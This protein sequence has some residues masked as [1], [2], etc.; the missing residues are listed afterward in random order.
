[1]AKII[2]KAS[3]SPPFLV[4]AG[5]IIVAGVGFIII[6]VAVNAARS[7]NWIHVDGGSTTTVAPGATV[8]VQVNVTTSGSGTNN[9]WRSTSYRIQSGSFTCVDTSDHT[10]SGT[11]TESFN[12]TAP[13]SEGTYD[14]DV[15]VYS[16]NSCQNGQTGGSL[17]NSII[18]KKPTATIIAKKIICDNE[19]DLPNWGNGGLDITSSTAQNWVNTHNKCRIAQWDF[20]WGPS[21]ASNPGDNTGESNSWTT[22]GS[23]TTVDVSGQSK[24]WV[25]EVWDNQFIPFT[26]NVYGNN[27]HN[28]SAEVYCHT[29]VLNYD[30]YDSIDNPQ[31]G[32][33]YYCVGFNVLNTGSLKVNKLVDQRWY[34]SEYNIGNDEANTMGFRWN[35]DSGSANEM[36]STVSGLSAG[37]HQV[38]EQ[39]IADYHFTG[40]FTN[41]GDHSCTNPEGTTLPVS[42]NVNGSQ[43]TEI[44][45]CNSRD[46]GNVNMQKIVI[47]HHDWNEGPEWNFDLVGPVSMQ[48]SLGDGHLGGTRVPTGQYTLTETPYS[49]VGDDIYD[50]TYRCW[51][52]VVGPVNYFA[53]GNGTSVSFTLEKNQNIKCEFTNTK[54]ATIIVHKNVKSFDGSQDI[55]DNH[56]FQVTA[57]GETKNFSEETA[58]TFSVAPGAYN[59]VESPDQNYTFYRC[60]TQFEPSG[61]ITN[62]LNVTVS[63]GQTAEMTC[64][65]YKLANPV[66]V[67]T[68]SVDK[69][70]ANEGDTLTYTIKVSNTGDADANNLM[71]TDTLPT[72]TTFVSADNGGVYD[73]ATK[74]LTW[75]INVPA[76]KDVTL[77]YQV[78]VNSGLPYG[79][80]KID[81]TAVVKCRPIFRAAAET[82]FA[83]CNISE[84]SSNKVTTTVVKVAETAT[85]VLTLTKLDTPDPV[86]A[87]A[88]LTYT[89]NFAVTNV[90]ATGVVMTDVIPTNT[91]FVSASTPGTYDTLTNKVTWNFGNLAKGNYTATLVVN[92]YSPLANGTKIN[93]TATINADGINPVIASADTTVSSGPI[94]KMDKLVDKAIANAGDTV[95]Y[96]IKVTNDGTDT[97][98]NV[99]VTDTLPA[100]FT[101]EAN[102]QSTINYDFGDIIAGQTVA[103]SFS[104]K[105]DASVV[106]GTY[107]NTATLTASNYA[108]LSAAKSIDVKNPTVLGVETEKPVSSG[109]VLGAETTLPVTGAPLIDSVLISLVSAA[110]ATY[111]IRKKI[112]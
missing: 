98:K 12:I 9:D 2:K 5:L 89:L 44:T 51:L 22:F 101:L 79:E 76:N 19:A 105:I 56:S 42:I 55:S 86:A 87:G 16:D 102:G 21:N 77:T 35:V 49:G 99:K 33:T 47:P 84:T 18:V 36:G 109:K 104:V 23:Q 68:K 17:D 69:T 37:S 31:A 65:N 71:V 30:N 14:L 93:N 57:N 91:S 73:A 38:N 28:V 83:S 72:N 32:Q 8:G 112:F 74:T 107:T 108:N 11:Y 39:N 75:Y 43:T 6:P 82:V 13:S 62:G 100:G 52:V 64:I 111:V 92:V 85:P 10:S 58:A 81:N 53:Q 59:V 3:K 27:N 20:Q 48:W 26:Y 63:A 90:D 24:I 103:T 4:V 40:W 94:L 34:G 41:G 96:T 50:A 97:A 45:L 54:R 110:G 67:I 60:E 15:R 1:M 106:A 66:I 46:S 95:L 78:T 7:I 70:T 29:D 25:R 80:T 88:N 61:Q